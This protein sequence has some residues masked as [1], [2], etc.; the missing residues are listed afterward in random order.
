MV[1]EISY[2]ARRPELTAF[3]EAITM[4]TARSGRL[5]SSR[6]T[7][8]GERR[9]MSGVIPDGRP[10][11][12]DFRSRWAMSRCL[13]GTMSRLSQLIGRD[14]GTDTFLRRQ[15]PRLSQPSCRFRKTAAAGCPPPQAA[16]GKSVQDLPGYILRR[17]LR[18]GDEVPS[19]QRGLREVAVHGACGVHAGKPVPGA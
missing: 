15:S 11:R 19:I 9:Q 18:M 10:E 17:S 6:R 16:V 2:H 4:I 14:L 12:M 5:K 7:K 13:D 8:L 1:R 3:E